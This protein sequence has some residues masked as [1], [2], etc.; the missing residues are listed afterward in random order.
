MDTHDKQ[1]TKG[2]S[3]TGKLKYIVPDIKTT[4][5]YEQFALSCAFADQDCE[6]EGGIS[7]G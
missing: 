4:V 5:L 6:D 1:Y 7:S 2:K 3:D